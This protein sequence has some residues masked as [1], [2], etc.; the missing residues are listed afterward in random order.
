MGA[1]HHGGNMHRLIGIAV[2]ALVA[3]ACS[4]AGDAVVVSV[5][6]DATFCSVFDGEYR[7]ALQAAVPITDPSFDERAGEI[8]AWA[9]VLA[10]LAPEDVAEFATDNVAYHRAQAEKR[11]AAPF[12]AG[13]NALHEFANASC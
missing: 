3:G 6:A 5:P 13:S 8:V 1:S 12:I 2:L 7:T 4:G 10:D 9:E 11:T